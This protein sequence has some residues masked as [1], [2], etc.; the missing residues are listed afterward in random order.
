EPIATSSGG[1]Y[2]NPEA[3]ERLNLE[4]GENRKEDEGEIF[5]LNVR[6]QSHFITRGMNLDATTIRGYNRVY[7]KS[8]S[9]L[10]ITTRGG[11]PILTVWN[12][13]LGRVASLTTDNGNSWATGDSGLYGT[14]KGKVVSG[15]INWVIGDL[16]KGKKVNIRAEDISLGDSEEISVKAS[17]APSLTV[18]EVVKDAPYSI[19]LIRT[20]PEQYT[21]TFTPA[22]TGFYGL[23]AT[24]SGDQDLDAIAVNYPK[25]Y[26]ELGLNEGVLESI[27][28][29]T[30][31][32]VYDSSE[33][34]DFEED[35]LDHV[36][37][38]STQEIIN[39][40]QLWQYFAA[41]ALAFY[42]IDVIAR[43]LWEM[44][45]RKDVD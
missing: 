1:L 32:M 19:S 43:R 41:L 7:E 18:K 4:F 45:S 23:R 3:Q 34:K 29:A 25:E 26:S 27:T 28:G 9:Q 11:Q 8:A 37:K 31:G 6:D 17:A 44:L 13:G 30:G 24:A 20:G 38:V 33:L 22:N 16:E 15:M 14:F 10:L 21:G 2:F 36:K 5:R 42:F 40:T 12:F 35:L 39:E